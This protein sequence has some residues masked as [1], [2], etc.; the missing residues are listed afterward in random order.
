MTYAPG[1]TLGASLPAIKLKVTSDQELPALTLGTAPLTIRVFD[2][3]GLPIDS[4]D[5]TVTVTDDTTYDDRTEKVRQLLVTITPQ[6]SSRPL[7]SKVVL[8]IAAFATPDVTVTTVDMKNMSKAAHHTIAVSKGLADNPDRPEV[9][10]IQR[11]RPGSQTVV[12]AFQEA[13]VTGAFDVRIVLTEAPAEFTVAYVVVANGTASNFVVGAPFKRIANAMKDEDST[14]LPHPI[15]GAY[16][17]SAEA[18]DGLAGVPQGEGGMT[19]TVPL[20]TN[21]NN[22]MY[23]QYRVTI[24]PHRRA[25]S[26]T[27]TVGTFHDGASPYNNYYQPAVNAGSTPNGR[28]KLELKVNIQKFNLEDGLRVYLPHNDG[29]K[30]TYANSTAG[31]YILVRL[32]DG[33]GMRYFNHEGADTPDRENKPQEQTPAQLLYNVRET[34]AGTPSAREV[35]ADAPQVELPNMERFLANS[36]TDS[37]GLL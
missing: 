5:Y 22:E 17:H 2:E 25:T 12:A 32:K 23:S 21:D 11:L 1:A 4:G 37:L 18:D 10:S 35:T 13:E 6:L 16:Y 31:H 33:S 9:V 36:G 8:T 34:A 7:V 20:P 27:V 29:A 3:D 19:D 14:I 15:E 24:T 26:V 28:E 30:I